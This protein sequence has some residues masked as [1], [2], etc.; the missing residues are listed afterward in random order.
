VRITGGLILI[1]LGISS[2]L[3]GGCQVVG[4]TADMPGGI[5]A[6]AKLSEEFEAYGQPSD[7]AL[8]RQLKARSTGYGLLASGI[9]VT[10]GGACCLIAGILFFIGRAKWFVLTAAG[11]G[12]AG[13]LTCWIA[14]GFDLV[15][16]IKIVLYVLAGIGGLRLGWGRSQVPS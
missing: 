14:V 11:L 1:V 8:R 9:V 3:S 13:E 5:W 10:M 2:L 4:G 15:G 7:H 12:V 6:A 16:P